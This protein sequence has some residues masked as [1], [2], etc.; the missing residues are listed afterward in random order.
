MYKPVGCFCSSLDC[1]V[2]FNR[3]TISHEALGHRHFP[4]WRIFQSCSQDLNTCLSS[5]TICF[6]NQHQL[7]HTGEKRE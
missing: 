6:V 3:L 1:P 5:L 2:R 7:V 4:A